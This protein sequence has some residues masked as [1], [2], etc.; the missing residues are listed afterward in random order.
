VI[1]LTGHS[2]EPDQI[3]LATDPQHADKLKEMEAVLQAEMRRLHDP[4]RLWD[5]PA[6]GLTPPPESPR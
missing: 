4:R 6:D 5:Q 3:N 1:A 2:P